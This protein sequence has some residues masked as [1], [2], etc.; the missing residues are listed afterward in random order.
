MELRINTSSLLQ[1]ILILLVLLL[2]QWWHV[3]CF[4]R[5]IEGICIQF[6][7]FLEVCVFTEQYTFIYF[8]TNSSSEPW[9]IDAQFAVPDLCAAMM[10]IPTAHFCNG[11]SLTRTYCESVFVV[12]VPTS[13]LSKVTVPYN[14]YRQLPAPPISP[15]QWFSVS[16]R[17]LA[18]DNNERWTDNSDN[19]DFLAPV[20]IIRSRN[21]NHT[22]IL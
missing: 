13:W 9:G 17:G 8:W 1:Y 7:I 14:S 18:Q 16:P 5:Y 3:L 20:E 10:D 12:T 11:N 6:H 2:T 21:H 22:V 19:T 15:L 4:C